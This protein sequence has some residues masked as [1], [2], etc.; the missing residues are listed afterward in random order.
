MNTRRAVEFHIT[1]D[2]HFVRQCAT[3]KLWKLRT[4]IRRGNIC[5]DCRAAAR[6]KKPPRFSKIP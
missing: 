5:D 6:K 4:V 3:C 2:G 1:E